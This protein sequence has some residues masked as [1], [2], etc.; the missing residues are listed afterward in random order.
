MTLKSAFEEIKKA[1]KAK[2]LD[3]NMVESFLESIQS[4]E[5]FIGDKFNYRQVTLIHTREEI[6][7]IKDNSAECYHVKEV[8]G[9]YD[10]YC[11]IVETQDYFTGKKE[12][13]LFLLDL[14]QLR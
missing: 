14:D 11:E 2:D 9:G 7:K 6:D 5:R 8:T 1:L 13:Y 12:L 4:V 3:A 10:F